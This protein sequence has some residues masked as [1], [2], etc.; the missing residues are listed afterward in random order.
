MRGVIPPFLKE[1]FK[2]QSFTFQHPFDFRPNISGWALLTK[3]E[4]CRIK[5]RL[6]ELMYD[7]ATT[8]SEFDDLVITSMWRSDS[9]NKKVGGKVNSKHLDGF[10]IDVRLN[11]VSK[12]LKSC[13]L[14]EVIMSNNCIHIQRNSE[15]IKQ[16]VLEGM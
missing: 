6:Y 15:F 7:L 14:Y 9:N 16:K 11:A 3:K 12:K 8:F 4:R 10:A 2:M 5:H 13:G 1:R